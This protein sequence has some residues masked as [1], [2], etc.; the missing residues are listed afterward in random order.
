MKVIWDYL[1]PRKNRCTRDVKSTLRKQ[2]ID[3]Y[4]EEHEDSSLM[5]CKT[6]LYTERPATIYQ[7]TQCNIPEDLNLQRHSC[8]NLVNHTR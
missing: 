2:K 6:L 7:S 8:E 4:K 1:K 5:E 3:L